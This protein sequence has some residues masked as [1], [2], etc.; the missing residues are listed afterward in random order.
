MSTTTTRLKLRQPERG[1]GGAPDDLVNV[2]SDVNSNMETIDQKI[3]CQVVTSANRPTEPFTGQFIFETDTQYVLM[4]DGTS[5][6]V[7]GADKF[8]K[9]KVGIATKNTDNALTASTENGPDQT[10]TF[11]ARS[12]RR[13]Q[14]EWH[15]YLKGPAQ[16]NNARFRW[17]TG[18]SV[19]TTGTQIGSDQ[20]C[21]LHNSGGNVA[22]HYMSMVQIGPGILPDGQVT[23]GA[24]ISTGPNAITIEG[25]IAGLETLHRDYLIRDVGI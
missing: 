4:W 14:V 1:I 16:V 5:W 21:S 17:A 23:V 10:I 20:L 12:D 13:Y 3:N 6:V 24:F 7:I 15:F 8:A 25:D 9:G 22:E 19:T 11:T 18:T 2:S